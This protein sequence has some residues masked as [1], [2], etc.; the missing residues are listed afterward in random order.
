MTSLAALGAPQVL[1]VSCCSVA[2]SRRRNDVL[3]TDSGLK[4][5]VLSHLRHIPMR[6]AGT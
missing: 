5:G 1:V 3:G 4:T 6:N 2:N